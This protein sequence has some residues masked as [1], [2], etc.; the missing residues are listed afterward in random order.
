M[1]FYYYLIFVIFL[2][3]IPPS[4]A[5]S[6]TIVIPGKNGTQVG[7]VIL[8]EAEIGVDS[9]LPLGEMFCVHDFYLVYS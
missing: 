8:P 3:I 2:L 9:Y 5:D 7:L 1:Y 6:G 4:S